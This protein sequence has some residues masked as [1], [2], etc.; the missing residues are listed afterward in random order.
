FSPQVVVCTLPLQPWLERLDEEARASLATGVGDEAGP[1]FTRP[2]VSA[3]FAPPR[4]EVER[5]LASLWKGLLGV[6]EVGVNDDFF[7]LGGQSLVA[8]RLFQRI[9]RKYGVE[10]PLSALFQAPTIAECA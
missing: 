8:V 4:D 5:E 9:G 3:T 2:S 10:L 1:V 6:A 7:E